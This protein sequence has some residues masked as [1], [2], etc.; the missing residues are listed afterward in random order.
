M[1]LRKVRKHISVYPNFYI[2]T[3][4][5][6]TSEAIAE[7]FKNLFAEMKKVLNFLGGLCQKVL[8]AKSKKQFYLEEI[9]STLSIESFL[10]LGWVTVNTF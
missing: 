1:F 8:E 4:T 2:L 6:N 10:E 3:N 7:E 9:A 5:P